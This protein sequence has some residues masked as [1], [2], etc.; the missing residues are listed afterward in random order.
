LNEANS[1]GGL[2]HHGRVQREP[3]ALLPRQS[4]DARPDGGLPRQGAL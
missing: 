2:R 4:G 1:G 3:A